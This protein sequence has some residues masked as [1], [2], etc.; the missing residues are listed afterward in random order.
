M[1]AIALYSDPQYLP[2]DAPHAEILYPFWGEVPEKN[3]WANDRRFD[4]YLEC[5]RN[6]FKTV[7]SPEEADFCVLPADWKFYVR[8]GTES[9]AVEFAATMRKY[10]K[11]VLIFLREDID[12]EIPIDNAIVFRTSIYR[13]TRRPREFALPAWTGD[14]T[15]VYLGGELPVRAK[16]EKPTIGF[17]GFV[18]D[19][20]GLNVLKSSIRRNL[21]NAAS[22]LGLTDKRFDHLVF[23]RKLLDRLARDTRLHTDFILR[24]GWYA[25]DIR[26]EKGDGLDP[27]VIQRARV[28]YIRNLIRSDYGIAVRGAGNYSFRFYEILSLGRIPLFID[29]DCVLPYDAEIDWRQYCIWIDANDISSIS[30][31]VLE[32]HNRLSPS[33]FIDLQH[34]CRRVYLDWVSPE[35]FFDKFHLHFPRS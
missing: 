12:E 3:L 27:G 31:I 24:K 8:T 22:L 20:T 16:Q 25:A 2:P 34:E 13:S 17:C 14:F 5:G 30:D 18:Y 29:T 33:A 26:K 19:Q 4:R 9:R 32:F 11:S 28:E 10:Q 23:R 6:L 35:G 1:D 21:T 15:A 7:A